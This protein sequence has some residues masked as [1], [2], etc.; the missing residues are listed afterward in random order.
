MNA[1][2]VIADIATGCLTEVE[3]AA[4]FYHDQVRGLRAHQ[5]F[6]IYPDGFVV[7]FTCADGTYDVFGLYGEDLDTFIAYYPAYF[8]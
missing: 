5:R 7:S 1:S 2:Q 8:Y 6:Y 3:D 4:R